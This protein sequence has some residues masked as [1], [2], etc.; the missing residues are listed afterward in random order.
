MLALLI[1]KHGNLNCYVSCFSIPESPEQRAESPNQ[2]RGTESPI[3]HSVSSVT[4]EKAK[5]VEKKPKAK[6][7]KKVPREK[8]DVAEEENPGLISALLIKHNL[9]C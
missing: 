7:V 5:S 1:Y 3:L 9:T 6:A 2:S 4:A 8:N